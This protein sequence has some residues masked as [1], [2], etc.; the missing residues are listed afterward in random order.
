MRTEKFES[1]ERSPSERM[2]PRYSI[3]NQ[4]VEKRVWVDLFVTFGFGSLS[5][6]TMS[7]VLRVFT[8]GM[9]SFAEI[10]AVV[11]LVCLLAA[12]ASILLPCAALLELTVLRP[13]RIRH[14][15][16]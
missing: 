16:N 13:H 15:A 9:Y 4:R 11:T 12:I 14:I 6:I 8:R 5:Q 10:I 7:P 1:N 2:Y 3:G